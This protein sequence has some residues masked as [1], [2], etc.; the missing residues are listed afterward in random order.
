MT[1]GELALNL[2]AALA[3][4]GV[5]VAA[6]DLTAVVV[7]AVVVADGS[8]WRVRTTACWV[9]TWELIA[10]AGRM[11]DEHVHDA[12]DD[13]SDTL[14]RLNLDGI[15]NGGASAAP[16]ARTV[17]DVDYLAVTFTLTDYNLGPGRPC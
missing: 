12:M 11:D 13:L 17:G 2:G 1:R 7:P 15:T 9:K 10:L 3:P 6:D 4:Y 8:P 14:C 16:T 5:A